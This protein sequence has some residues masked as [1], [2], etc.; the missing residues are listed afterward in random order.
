M[1]ITIN[2]YYKGKN[3]SARKFAQEMCKSGIVEKIRTK[4][5]NLKYEYFFPMEDEDTVLLID[6]WENQQAID[7]HHASPVME[8]ISKLRDKYDLH[9]TVERYVT[10]DDNQNI[11]QEYI[12]K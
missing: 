3:G 8:V 12:R 4:K 6:S 11:D 7:E 5:G 9:M 1:A 2:I 10:D